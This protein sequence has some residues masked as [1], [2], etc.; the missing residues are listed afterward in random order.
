MT[1]IQQPPERPS[2][3]SHQGAE[4]GNNAD[5]LDRKD[6]LERLELPAADIKEVETKNA[7]D[8]PP[9]PPDSHPETTPEPTAMELPT[10]SLVPALDSGEAGISKSVMT[11]E[12]PQV[13]FGVVEVR[14]RWIERIAW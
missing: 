7:D 6:Q 10:D 5:F 12:Q 1:G 3:N 9:P 2:V 13:V 8:G 4:P 14:R 11:S